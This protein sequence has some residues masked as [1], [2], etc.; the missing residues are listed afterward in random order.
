[1]L[2]HL[3]RKHLSFAGSLVTDHCLAHPVVSRPGLTVSGTHCLP[4]DVLRQFLDTR[5]VRTEDGVRRDVLVAVG[6]LAVLVASRVVRIDVLSVALRGDVSWIDVVVHLICYG[7]SEPL[8][9][10]RTGKLV[11][12]TDP[13]RSI[14]VLEG[15][16]PP[17]AGSTH[18]PLVDTLLPSSQLLDGVLS[19]VARPST[20]LS[21]ASSHWRKGG[22]LEISHRGHLVV[23]PRRFG[24]S[25]LPL[26]QGQGVAVHLDVDVLLVVHSLHSVDRRLLVVV[27]FRHQ[28]FGVALFVR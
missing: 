3:P 19:R 23:T 17:L 26:F 22:C 13:F 5:E 12:R 25:E 2:R 18:V 20:G 8:D 14:I 28:Q 6:P 16:G 9:R 24:S 27:S 4:L 15:D 21:A 10:V 11:A 1:M 7:S